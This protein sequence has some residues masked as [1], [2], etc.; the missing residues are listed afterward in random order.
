MH[1]AIRKL[2]ETCDAVEPPVS[3]QE[4]AMRWI[5]HDSALRDGDGVIFGAKRVD[6]LE[7]NVLDVRKGPLPE[8]VVA[9]VEALWGMVKDSEP[10][11]PLPTRASAAKAADS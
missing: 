3:L 5:V 11:H 9:G 1:D 7:A 10:A 8:A 6:Q 4:A 2:K